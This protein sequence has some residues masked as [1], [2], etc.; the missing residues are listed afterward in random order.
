MITPSGVW[1]SMKSFVYKKYAENPGKMLLHTGAIGWI[2]SSAAQIS[3]I[4]MNDKLSA[5]DKMFLIPQ[6]GGDAFVN[7]VSFY[8]LTWG[9]KAIGEKLTK[10]CKLMSKDVERILKAK[11]HILSDKVKRTKSA[12]YAGDWD[13]DIT[14]LPEYESSIKDIYT[15]FANGVAVTTA[16]TGSIIS[17]NLVTPY[18]RNYLASKHQA[19][20]INH[21]N[22][23]KNNEDKSKIVGINKDISFEKFRYNK[24]NSLYPTSSGMKI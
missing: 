8:T 1:N 18:G 16:L 22:E 7:I 10:T 4:L 23:V 6:E 5:K 15:P 17:T 9:V 20:L 2:L 24:F 11:G 3:A 14:K 19:S 21:L 13:F 12:V